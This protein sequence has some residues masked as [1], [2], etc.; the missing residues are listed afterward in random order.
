MSHRVLVLAG[1]LGLAVCLEVPGRG[2]PQDPKKE[3]SLNEL[4][5]E[6]AAL[7][8]LYALD[9]TRPQVEQLRRLAADTADQTPGRK[10]A[11]G[12]A[13]LRRA[14]ME[15]RA[16]LLRGTDGERV[17]ALVKQID[18]I[19]DKEKPEL[20][21]GVEVTDGA[22]DK[23]PE[24][25][26]LLTAAQVAVYTG[27]M[28]GDIPDP[29]G[30]LLEAI[31]RVRGLQGK[32]WQELRDGVADEVG[33]LV[34][35]VDS[36]AA[37]AVTDKVKQLLIVARGLKDEEFKR[38]RPALEK[39]ARAMVAPAGPLEVLRHVMEHSLAELL[40]NPRLTA[41]LEARLR[42]PE[43]PKGGAAGARAERTT[44]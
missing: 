30:E 25:L 33:R 11:R 19:R 10:P 1:C 15:L 8:T 7:Q 41:V 31:A 4:S 42:V 16:A 18:A 22:R 38:Q 23:A 17:D 28:A 40:S 13:Q 32:E 5:L 44:P 14:L 35:G 20:D 2:A 3:P 34:G 12:S 43:T 26:R 29:T 24:V 39:S 36:D 6:V 21:D 27:G 37:Q 9:V